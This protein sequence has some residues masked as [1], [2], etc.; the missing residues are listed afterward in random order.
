VETLTK[1]F[2]NPSQEKIEFYLQTN[3]TVGGKF[4]AQK[5]NFM[6]KEEDI[7]EKKITIDNVEYKLSFTKVGKE[8]KIIVRK[9]DVVA[10]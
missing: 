9:G 2:E 5:M 6:T 8:Y 4:V 1:Y 7:D 10:Q 3:N